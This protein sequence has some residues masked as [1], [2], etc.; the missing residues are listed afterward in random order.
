MKIT[1]DINFLRDKSG[2]ICHTT[3]DA[4]NLQ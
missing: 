3:L 2:I 4:L 1:A